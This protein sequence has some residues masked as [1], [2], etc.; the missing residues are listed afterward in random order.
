MEI[1]GN[2]DLDDKVDDND[3]REGVALVVNDFSLWRVRALFH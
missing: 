3:N 1:V 2:T